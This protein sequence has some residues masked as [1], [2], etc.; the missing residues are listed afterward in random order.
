M[1]VEIKQAPL[2]FGYD[3][4]LYRNRPEGG[5][6][7]YNLDGSEREVVTPGDEPEPSFQCDEQVLRGLVEAGSD[8]LPPSRSMAKHLDDA[9]GVRDRLLSLIEHQ[10][11]VRADG[12]ADQ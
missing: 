4:Y 2:R 10:G 11:K 9:I 7:I 5:A 12:G 1:Q 6:T 8:V 3:V